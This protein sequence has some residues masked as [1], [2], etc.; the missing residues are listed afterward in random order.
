MSANNLTILGRLGVALA[1]GVLIGLERGW[2]L[3]ELAEGKRIAGFRTF[4]LISLLGALTIL[5]PYQP[6]AFYLAAVVVVVGIL[7]A[8]GYWRDSAS[9]E[10]ISLTT[11]VAAVVAFSLGALAGSGQLVAAAA[12]AV[13]VALLL[14]IKPELHHLIRDIERPELLATLRLLLISVV[15]LPILPDKGFGPWQA[16]N[17]Y[18]LWWMVVLIAAVSYVGHFGIRIL[19]SQ[20][21]VL[22]TG[23]LGG[24]FSST[25]VALTMA[26]RSEEMPESQDVLTAAVVA[27]SATMFPRMLAIAFAVMPE[28]GWRLL[29]PMLCASA[30][31]FLAAA[32]YARRSEDRKLS[33]D[34]KSLETSNPLDLSTALK[35]G[36]LLAV[37]MVLTRAFKYWMGDTGLYALGAASGLVDVDAITLSMASLAR[38]G[39]TP[40]AVATSVLLV[41][42]A[43]NSA[44]KAAIVAKIAGPRMSLQVTAALSVMLGAGAFG[45]WLSMLIK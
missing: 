28:L 24:L 5:L 44:V 6:Q 36:A 11:A 34:G 37:I 8:L 40:V 4:G 43:V 42:A 9:G 13:V 39:E 10:D 26:R 15:F 16:L 18:K 35:F 21:G 17:P 29:W 3:R 23:L 41:P 1:L 14:G 38:S 2:E 32:W 12:T 30:A 33:H 31:G 27:A 19:G 22:V 45:W 7:A 25:A 20:R